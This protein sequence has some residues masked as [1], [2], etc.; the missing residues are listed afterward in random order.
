[1][2]PKDYF[3]SPHPSKVIFKSHNF[4]IS[5]VEKYLGLSYNFTCNILSGASRITSENEVKLQK[6]VDLLEKEVL[7]NA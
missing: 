4:P 7:K 6:L 1:M 2:K 5:A 3:P